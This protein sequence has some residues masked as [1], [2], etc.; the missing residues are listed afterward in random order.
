MEG[1]DEYSTLDALDF[2]CKYGHMTLFEK[3]LQVC[4]LFEIS[5]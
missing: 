4:N 5:E 2:A 1:M 3:S